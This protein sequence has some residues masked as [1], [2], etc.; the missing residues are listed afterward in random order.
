MGLETQ[1]DAKK[2]INQ[3]L[4]IYTYAL[5][6]LCSQVVRLNEADGMSVALQ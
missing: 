4:N 6:Q 1:I 2:W 5:E 3:Q